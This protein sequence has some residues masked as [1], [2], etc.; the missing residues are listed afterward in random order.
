MAKTKL[1]KL[2][3]AKRHQK[4]MKKVR[5]ST[6]SGFRRLM[7]CGGV[8]RV[9]ASAYGAMEATMIVDITAILADMV[10][11]SRSSNR[12]TVQWCDLQQALKNRGSVIYGGGD[13]SK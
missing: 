7:R 2:E 4:K 12:K 3:P 11:L 6:D 8:K 1:T 13:G 9:A 5:P 10:T